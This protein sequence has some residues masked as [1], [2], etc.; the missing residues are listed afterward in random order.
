MSETTDNRLDPCAILDRLDQLLAIL[1][2][3]LA[4]QGGHTA[5]NN[6]NTE[7]HPHE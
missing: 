1:A 2:E 5:I 7:D 4:D 6:L 3:F